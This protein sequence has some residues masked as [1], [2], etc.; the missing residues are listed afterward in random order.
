V[1]EVTVLR[2]TISLASPYLVEIL[3]SVCEGPVRACV[4]RTVGSLHIL[5]VG[6]FKGINWVVIGVVT[7][8]YSLA[9]LYGKVWFL[10]PYILVVKHF[11]P[12]L[13]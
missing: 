13:H 6:V 4:A 12:V 3:I 8:F 10:Q 11:K 2:N 5:V 9:V 1:V 7:S